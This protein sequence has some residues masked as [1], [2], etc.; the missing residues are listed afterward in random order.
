MQPG[1]SG[2]II[3]SARQAYLDV[4]EVTIDI[5]WHTQNYYQI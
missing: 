4:G 1:I 3:N 5:T 2:D